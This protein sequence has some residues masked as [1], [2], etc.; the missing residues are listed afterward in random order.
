VAPINVPANLNTPLF[1]QVE[2]I[3]VEGNISYMLLDDT[4]GPSGS[5]IYYLLTANK[6][7]TRFVSDVLTTAL[8]FPVKH[9]MFQTRTLVLWTA[10]DSLGSAW[11]ATGLTTDYAFLEFNLVTNSVVAHNI[12]GYLQWGTAWIGVASWGNYMLVYTLERVYYSSPLNFK[13]FTPADGLGGSLKISE[14]QG[15]I[16]MIVPH[17][18]GFLIYCRR[19][20]VNAEY[21]GDPVAPFILTEVRDSA[22]LILFEGEPL[23]TRNEQ[24]AFQVALTSEGLMFVSPN[25]AQPAPP[26]LQN[27]VNLEYVEEREVGSGK[28]TRHFYPDSDN[29]QYRYN[30]LKRLELFGTKLFMLMGDLAPEAGN[31]TYNRM[32]VFDIQTEETLW[33]EGD[34]VSVVPNLNLL[35]S[36]TNTRDFQNKIPHIVE[37]Y[38]LTKRAVLAGQAT[39]KNIILDLANGTSST[40]FPV[41][42]YAFR[43]C[44]IM[45]SNLS[46]KRGYLTELYAVTP[47]GRVSLA[48]YDEPADPTTLL[49]VEVYSEL[50]GFT[51][52]QVF[53]WEPTTLKWVGFAV[54]AKL[55]VLLRGNYFVLNEVSFEVQLGG[56][57][58]G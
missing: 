16:Q 46:L 18:N 14:A 57:I 26:Q 12:T 20:I 56:L 9:T 51:T 30:K 31:E 17:S 23:V 50:D 49:S 34:I 2:V 28:I 21:S 42:A 41:G 11:S 45:F 25:G 15:P 32:C 40:T 43:P 47:V 22:G 1:R 6:Q 13:D 33:I 36:I 5:R 27:L 53:V 37:S 52:P 10:G 4:L 39:Y 19:N 44:E 48:E 55:R 58:D 35:K 8:Y 38:L 3:D 29:T 54:G 24:S 7:W